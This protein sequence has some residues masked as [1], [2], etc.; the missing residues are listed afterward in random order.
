M[1]DEQITEKKLYRL[2]GIMHL[3]VY[4]RAKRMDYCF[5]PYWKAPIDRLLKKPK[6]FEPAKLL[7]HNENDEN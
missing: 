1:I 2:R 7:D 4:K 6:R 5:T 3:K